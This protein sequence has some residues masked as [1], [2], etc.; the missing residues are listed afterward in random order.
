M[1]HHP[2][3]G[4]ALAALALVAGYA[5]WGARGL[6][7]AVTV[8]VFWLLLQFNRALRTTRRA[9]QAPMGSVASA[10]MLHAKLKPGLRL[11]DVLPLAGSLG[12][13]LAGAGAA[14]EE[15]YRWADAGGREVQVVL[16]RGRV[17]SW[18]LDGQ[19]AGPAG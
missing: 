17:V 9:A 10:V 14:D 4:W 2:A 7:L 12:E 15:R 19:P 6:V 5:G 11:A 3:I 1:G 16:R 13:P 8:I 18:T